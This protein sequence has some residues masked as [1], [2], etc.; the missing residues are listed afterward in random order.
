[1]N[2]GTF[3]ICDDGF[4]I[5]TMKYV[6]NKHRNLNFL[7]HKYL[8]KKYIDLMRLS[9]AL[10]VVWR[11][12]VRPH[13]FCWRDRYGGVVDSSLLSGLNPCVQQQKER[14]A[15]HLASRATELDVRRAG[16]DAVLRRPTTRTHEAQSTYMRR[17]QS[18]AWRL[19]KYW[20][21]TPLSSPTSECVLP[22]H[23]R[24]GVHTLRAVRGSIFWKTPA[25]G[26]AS[27]SL[28][29][30][31]HEGRKQVLKGNTRLPVSISSG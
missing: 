28:I 20:P 3:S 27:Y 21:P 31:R 22:P 24:R 11:E 7:T 1:M 15:L 19:P 30:L 16:D 6:A 26:L 23:Q 4:Q 25:I 8:L 10:M 12:N 14:G 18:C 29:S 9:L 17:V 2:T 5:S 13:L